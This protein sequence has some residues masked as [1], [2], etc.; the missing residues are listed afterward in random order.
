MARPI[1]KLLTGFFIVAVLLVVATLVSTRNQPPPASL[2]LPQP[3]GYDDLVQAGKMLADN[4]SDFATMSE[5]Q[6]RTLARRNAEALKLA[7]TGLSRACQVP[8]DYSAAG[9]YYFTNLAKLK[10]LA[11]AMTAEGRLAELGNRPAEAADAYLNVIRLGYAISQGGLLIDSLVGIAVE[12]IGTVNMEKLAPKLDAKQC[13]EAATILEAC[14][15]QR[16]PSQSVLARERTWARRAGGLKG[17]IA[18][19]VNYRSMKMSEQKIVSKLTA[20][21][22]REQVL[23]IQL[24]SRAYELE[25]GDRPNT[26]VQLV[27]TYLK[28]IPQNPIT[29][30]NMAFP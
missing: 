14:Q 18:R 1:A 28:A 19:L 6:L 9:Q 24:A 22:T 13:R 2:P 26:L 17:Q 15:G 30:T 27:P 23:L 21:Q 7:R 12:A 4:T 5:E 16:E 3:N 25:K 8:L 10:S 11:Q 29:G 20:Q